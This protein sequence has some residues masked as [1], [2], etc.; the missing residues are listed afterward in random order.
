MNNLTTHLDTLGLTDSDVDEELSSVDDIIQYVSSSNRLFR[1]TIK[2]ILLK[3]IQAYFDNETIKPSDDLTKLF[4]RKSRRTEWIKF[5]YYLDFK[6]PS[7]KLTLISIILM[8]I[9]VL[10]VGLIILWLVFGQTELFIHSALSKMSLIPVILMTAIIPFGLIASVGET[11]LPAKTVD[12][13]LDQIISKN[14]SDLL[15]D[16]KLRYKE[17]ILNELKED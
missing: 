6:V 7:L 12:E 5:S 8:T 1:K 10:G 11:V 13:L 3:D 16:D 2:H 15:T 4:P 14:L 9:I 17:M